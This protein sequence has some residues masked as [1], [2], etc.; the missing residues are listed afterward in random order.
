MSK[1][2]SL[3]EFEIIV[4]AAIMHIG[5]Q[6]YGTLVKEEIA[7][8]GG[9]QVSVG[10]LYSTLGRLESKGLL[11]SFEGEPTK[12]RGGRAKRYFRVTKSGYEALSKSID[13]LQSFIT[14]LPRFEH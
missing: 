14:E 4:M 9:R 6:A 5:E 10:A 2:Y 12:E 7:S 1:F 3:G 13:M 11:T 8:R